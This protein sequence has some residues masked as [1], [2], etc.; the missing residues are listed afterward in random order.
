MKQN[1]KNYINNKNKKRVSF[2]LTSLKMFFF[3]VFVFFCMI[4]WNTNR[5]PSRHLVGWT[6]CRA[7]QIEDRH[8]HHP[9][10]I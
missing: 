3:F 4:A 5:L 2:S 1:K 9:L 7:V 6:L 8:L 10:W